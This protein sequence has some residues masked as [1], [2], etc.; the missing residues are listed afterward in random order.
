ML[1][2]VKS[3][4]T[5][6]TLIFL[7]SSASAQN[8]DLSRRW[9]VGGGL[10]VTTTL[11]PKLYKDSLDGGGVGSLWVRYH[12]DSRFG[13]EL[14]YNRLMFE[15][16]S[17]PLESLDPV[18]DVIDV[19]IAYRA[20]P[21]ERLHMLVQLGLGYLHFTD[22]G[23]GASVTGPTVK[24]NDLALK[25]R[26]GAEYMVRE[27]I[28]LALQAD[29]YYLNLGSGPN[30]NLRTLVPL[31]SFTYYFGGKTA[32]QAPAVE[33]A[34]PAAGAMTAKVD[35]DKDGV[36]D[37]DDKCA[38]TP[39]GQKVNEFGCAPTE[40]MEFTLNVQFANGSSK[41]DDAFVAD[42]QRLA[43]FMT[44]YPAVKAEIEGHTDNTGSEKMNFS[45]SQ[46]R[47]DAVRKFL[48]TKSKIDKSRLTAKGYGPS[49]PVAD[50]NTPEGR[51]KNRRVVAHVSN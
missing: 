32:D 19:S 29:Y 44:K 33:A 10:G 22:V 41:I 5:F 37:A 50:N 21:K 49:Q 12:Y 38:G 51:M 1:Y 27:N 8:Y 40:K 42:V 47:A 36:A 18:A 23:S 11:S 9:G 30:S 4:L 31:A 45:I 34:A 26:L 14:A 17:G 48:I 43:D 13:V 28:A 7:A 16:K 25:A 46:K 35:T 2:P 24:N 15:Y 3:L 20:W 39:A 6:I